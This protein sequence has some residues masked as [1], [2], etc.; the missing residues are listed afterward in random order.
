[1]LGIDV[2][3][4]R[5]GAL[6]PVARLKPVFVGG[7]TVTNATLHNEDE[8]R[9]KDVRIGDTVVVRRAGDVIPEVVARA[10]RSAAARRA[11]CSRC[12][13]SARCAA[14]RWCGSRTRPR[15]AA[16]AAC[17]ARRSAS[18]RCCTSPAAARWTS[19]AWASKLVDQLVDTELVRTPADLYRLDVATARGPGAHGARSRP[20]TWSPSI[21][22]L[23]QHDARS[24]SSTR[25]ASATW[26]R[27]R[28][29]TSR[30]TSATSSRS[31]R[32]RARRSCSQVPD[33]GPGGRALDRAVLRRA[34]QPRGDRATCA[35][36]GVRWPSSDR[37]ARR[38]ARR[39]RK[40]L[41]AHR[42]AAGHEPRRGA[43][44]RSRRRGTR[45]RARCRRRP[46]TWS[47][48]RTP[49]ASS[50]RRASS[51]SPCSTK[52]SSSNCWQNL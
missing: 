25:S 24:A 5:T 7:V 19:R 2:Q 42:H 36:A 12:R 49:A 11:R 21:E 48:A 35:P 52:R 41:R 38:G 34:A 39:R 45:W 28:R 23:A 4:G 27:R 33:V 22:Q 32:G 10:A 3:V 40:T 30:A 14:R 50:T 16:P 1:M 15:T 20:P 44:P 31:M 37:S 17:S 9:R 13:R 47:P 43:A 26:A 18:R 29:A 51:A 6:T 46:T 8:L